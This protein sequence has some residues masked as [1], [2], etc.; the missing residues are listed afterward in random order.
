MLVSVLGR[1]KGDFDGLLAFYRMFTN[2]QGLMNWQLLRR[3]SGEV[4]LCAWRLQSCLPAQSA[5]ACEAAL[6][7]FP[8][9]ASCV[10]RPASKRAR[11]PDVLGTM[12]DRG[13]PALQQLGVLH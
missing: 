11:P 5:G 4:R 10:L 9:Y 12:R 13:H 7:T 2:R 1:N 3:R 8:E 6:A